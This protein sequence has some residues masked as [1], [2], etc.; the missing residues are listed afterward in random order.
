VINKPKWYSVLLILGLALLLTSPLTGCKNPQHIYESNAVVVGGDG[1]PIDLINNPYATNPTYAVLEAFIVNDPT[2]TYVYSEDYSCGDFAED[3]HNN[4]EAMGIKAGWVGIYF[5]GEDKGHACNVFQTTDRGLVYIDCTG[6]N[7]EGILTPVTFPDDTLTY[8]TTS[9]DKVAYVE[10]GREYGI[11]A[12]D[13]ADSPLYSYYEEFKQDWQEYER[14][15]N[16]YNDEVTRY[17]KS[18]IG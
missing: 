18:N 11:I 10:V 3:V 5:I 14:L 8:E 16:E 12:I 9:W 17:K 7:P 6:S 4:A 2:D 1:A 15:L 13:K